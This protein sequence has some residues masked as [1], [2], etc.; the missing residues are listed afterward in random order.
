MNNEMIFVH[1]G[2]CG[3]STV[4]KTLKENNINFKKYHLRK[5]YY[6]TSHKYLI[7]VR[8]PIQRLISVFNWRYFL[9]FD[10]KNHEVPKD[11]IRGIHGEK[12]LFKKYKTLDELC[13][14]MRNDK[15]F[16][17]QNIIKGKKEKKYIHHFNQNLHFYLENIIDNCPKEQIL[18]VIC[19]ETLK[20]DLKN[21][22]NIEVDRRAKHNNKRNYKKDISEENYKFLKEYLKKDYIIIDKMYKKGWISTEQYNILSK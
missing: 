9:V 10:A 5:P 13:D 6:K 8:N 2:K 14:A 16:I 11:S 17:P 12:T 21:I 18:G 7:L 20:D 15:I 3:G 22:L 4:G 1:V 19:Q